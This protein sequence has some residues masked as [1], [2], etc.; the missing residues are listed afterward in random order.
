MAWLPAVAAV[1]AIGGTAF[2]VYSQIE[3]GRVQ[4][5]AAYTTALREEA[6]GRQ[7]FASDQ[8]EALE[9]KIAGQLVES[10]QQAVAAA[11]GGGAGADAPT[12]VKLMSDT[13]ARAK[14]GY[15]SA[16]YGAESVRQAYYDNAAGRRRGGDNTFFGSLMSAGGS[17]FGGIGNFAE[18]QYRI[19]PPALTT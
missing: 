15:Q 6:A 7:G 17:L 4:K 1:A 2:S 18:T 10:R 8:R 3:Q 12:I 13:H 19:N 11:S 5:E 14:T 16:I 9:R